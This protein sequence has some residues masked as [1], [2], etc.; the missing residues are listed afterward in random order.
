MHQKVAIAFLVGI[1][2][3]S[4]VWAGTTIMPAR[5]L[6]VTPVPVT[7]VARALIRPGTI[8]LV[9]IPAVTDAMRVK[10]DAPI[11]TVA[12]KPMRV[13]T[14]VRAGGAAPTPLSAR[15]SLQSLQ[16]LPGG[17]VALQQVATGKGTSTAQL[18]G[19]ASGMRPPSPSPKAPTDWNA[20][21]VLSLHRLATAANDAGSAHLQLFNTYLGGNVLPATYWPT[22]DVAVIWGADG[23]TLR[24]IPGHG[25]V[26]GYGALAARWTIDDQAYAESQAYMIEIALRSVEEGLA[27][28]PHIY[29]NGSYLPVARVGNSDRYLGVASIHGGYGG[30]DLFVQ[31]HWSDLIAF[32]YIKVQ[33]IA[34]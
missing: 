19:S 23:T 2:L 29:V 7:P 26:D 1:V 8:A 22:N 31:G 4:A 11:V 20:G 12:G 27:F 33:R 28:Q 15:E 14:L 24:D 3:A 25:Q 18:V 10:L 34:G 9:E 30:V 32:Y 21:V 5:N 16:Q 6:P 13:P 17:Q